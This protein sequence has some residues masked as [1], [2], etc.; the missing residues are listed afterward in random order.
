MKNE[1]YIMSNGL[2]AI[3]QSVKDS[4]SVSLSITVGAGPY[5]ESRETA[6]LAHFLE[7]MLF[8]GTKAFPSP[9]LVIDYIEGIGGIYNAFTEKD[10]VI[11]N[12]KILPE[13]IEKG[14]IFIKE[15]L[16][17]SLLNVQAIELEKGIISE[18]IKRGKDNP[19]LEIWDVFNKWVWGGNQS[20]GW[21]TLGDSSTIVNITRTNLLEYMNNLYQPSNMALSVVGNVN[22]KEIRTIIDKF[23]PNNSSKKEI[24]LNK[25][26][27]INTNEKLKIV[28][29]SSSQLYYILGFPNHVNYTNTDRYVVSLIATLLGGSASARISNKLIYDLGIAYTVGAYNFVWRDVGL[30]SIYGG[31]SETNLKNALKVVID[32]LNRL[33][34]EKISESELAELKIK[35]KSTLLFYTE[36]TDSIADM[37]SIQMTTEGKITPLSEIV[38]EIEKV[39]IDDIY[40]VANYLF[41]SENLR[42][43]IRGNIDESFDIKIESLLEG[44]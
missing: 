42:L 35:K 39:N 15:I 6:G 27:I 2:R 29:D 40:R 31:L 10:Y 28:N 43:L 23:F 34:K 18:E 5:Y 22:P 13:N 14:L 11:F 1:E 36:T 30:F 33:K 8:E 3:I 32:E 25:V 41:K 21:S 37:Y 16:F 19:E 9:K 26:N 38:K 44:F 20:I 24:S 12:V 17:N 4:T 7:H